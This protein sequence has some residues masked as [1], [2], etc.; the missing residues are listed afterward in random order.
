MYKF[1]TKN[2]QTMALLLGVFC[3]LVFLIPVFTGIGGA[4]YDLGTDLNALPDEAKDKINFFNPGLGLAR[5]LVYAGFG[6]AL[7]FG[8]VNFAKFPRASLKAAGGLVAIVV[9]F[10]ILY[11]T[12]Q[13]ES[14]GKLAMLHDK[15]DVSEGVSKFISGGLKTTVFLAV[16]AFVIMILAEIRNFFK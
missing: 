8:I 1:L 10:F 7:I 3:I 6:L 12:S 2:G 9:L 14:T 5:F 11:S 13:M 15:F 4:G 16:G